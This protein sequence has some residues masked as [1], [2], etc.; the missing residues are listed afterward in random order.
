MP[1]LA[2]VKLRIGYIGFSA[3][4]ALF[5]GTPVLHAAGS[6]P[7]AGKRSDIFRTTNLWNVHFHF[8]PD[9]WDTMMPAEPEGGPFGGRPGRPGGPGG[10]GGGFGPGMFLSGP[11]LKA[12]DTDHDKKLSTQEFSALAD[13]W[14]TQWDKKKAGVLQEDDLREGLNQAIMGGGGGGPGIRLQ[15]SEGKRNGLA[16]AS[17]IEFKYVKAD[18]KI[19]DKAVPNVAVRYKGNGTW[20]GSRFDKKRSMKVELNEFVKGQKFA[21]E[22][23]LNFHNCVTDASFMN[24]V[25]SYRLYRDAGVPASRSAYARVYI[26]VPGKFQDEYF[27]LYSVVENVDNAFAEDRFGTKKGAIVKPVTREPFE[28][29]GDDWA[30][31]NQTYDPKTALSDQEK[32]KVI[33]F[34]KLVSNADDAEFRAHL[35][36]Y[37]DLDNFSR[38]MA[39]TVWLSTLDSIL[40]IGQNYYVYLNPKTGKLNF[41]P[42]DL[43]HSFGQFFLVGSPE[44][45]E[46][47][48]ITKPWQGQIRFLERVFATRSFQDLYRARME[49]FSKTIFQPDRFVR[50]VDELA[51]ALRPAVKDESETK[52]ARFDKV[53]AGESVPPAGFGPPE[54]GGERGNRGDRGGP[55]G[56]GG[57]GGGFMQ[58][59]RPIKGFVAVRAESVKE[60]LSGKA[61]GETV[62]GGF[63][64]G[65]GGGR[66]GG[67]GGPGGPGGGGFGPGNFLAPGFIA[68]LDADKNGSLSRE[69]FKAGFV[70]WFKSWDKESSGSLTEDQLRAGLNETF[71]PPG[72]GPGGPEGPGG[73]RNRGGPGG[74]GPGQ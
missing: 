64:P 17:G 58:P 5:S 68:K 69:E 59:A 24:E 67:R 34:C 70:Q 47:L 25:L 11:F 35:G 62:D 20:M 26:D 48:S 33:D 4:L 1:I 22:A 45:R 52:L 32:K 12:G 55:G 72:D 61:T 49:E 6:E 50:Q 63:G 44:Q 39:V 23:K 51:T 40:G 21:G 57:P 71:R 42:W 74:P 38:Y 18:L 43:D 31:Y 13:T 29:L 30:K 27:G 14:F 46:K 53:V 19:G 8:L 9:Q 2:S 15:G 66:P 60:Q 7:V 28:Y 41:I 73:R 65:G 37:L 36:D 10:P 16:S 3:A 56:P 54:G